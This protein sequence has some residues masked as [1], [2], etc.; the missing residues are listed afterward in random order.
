[1]SLHIN[2]QFAK[3][4]GIEK[5]LLLAIP[6]VM[7]E[8]HVILAAGTSTVRLA[9]SMRQRSTT[10]QYYGRGLRRYGPADA[11]WP[12]TVVGGQV[13]CQ[14]NGLMYAGF[15]K[16]PDPPLK[17]GKYDDT[18]RF[19]FSTV[20]WVFVKR[21]EA[22]TMRCGC[23]L[24]LLTLVVITHRGTNMISAYLKASSSSYELNKGRSKS[25]TKNKAT[26]RTHQNHPYDQYV[27]P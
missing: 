11:T 20:P 26:I 19:L 17:S 4:R 22:A 16:P 6:A 23:I 21:I 9:P 27:L 5:K 13:R 15:L 1:M 14:A 18:V 10:H 2:N 24:H 25:H 7:L 3:K 8:E 12:H